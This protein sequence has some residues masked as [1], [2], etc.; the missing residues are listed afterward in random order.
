MTSQDL[1]VKAQEALV[2]L[3]AA[4][5]NIRLYPPASAMV[6]K[7]IERVLTFLEAIFESEDELSVAESEKNLL[8]FGTP[9]TE[10]ELQKP[11]VVAFIATLLDFGVKSLAI[12]KGVATEELEVLFQTLSRKAEDVNAEGGL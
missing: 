7:S 10:K 3:N 12:K 1:H 2:A 6:Q 9:L 5:K 8:I 11:Q 4:I